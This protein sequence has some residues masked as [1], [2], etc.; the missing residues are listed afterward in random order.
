MRKRTVVAVLLLAAGLPVATAE[1]AVAD[2]GG[3]HAR[4]VTLI[5]GDRVLVPEGGR[6]PTILPAAGR[7][8]IAVHTH[9]VDGHVHVIPVDALPLVTAKRL[10]PR[11][12]DITGLLAA[13]YDDRRGDLPLIH[14]GPATRAPGTRVVRDLPALHAR[15][16]QADKATLPTSWRALTAAG[17]TVW[18][19]GRRQLTL[20]RSTAQIGAPEAWRS[21]LTGAGVTVAVLDTGV[22]QTHPDL[23]GREVAERNFTPAP[24]AV[25]RIGHGTH[26]ASI[27]AGGGGKY[28]GVANGARLL[29]A[30]VLDDTGFGQDSWIIAGMEWA[31]GQGATIV[32]LSL[33]GQDTPLLDPLEEA[34][35]RLSAEHGTLFVV[36]A[37]NNGIPGTIGSPA[38]A[39]AALAVG[40]VERDDSIAQFSSRG[41]RVGDGAIKPDITGPGVGIIA[42]K[43]AEGRIGDPA[44]PGYVRL[45]GTSMATPH[46]AGAAALLAQLHP[47]WTG[48]QLKAALTS[49]AKATP[50]ENVFAQGSG[51]VDVAAAIA[52]TV[53]SDP[54]S[55][56]LG[57]Q[58]WPHGDDVPVTKEITYRNNSTEPATL[59]LAAEAIGP[60]GKPA[61][62]G[63]IT[64]APARVVLPG[65]GSATARITADTRIGTLDGQ[66]TGA[67]VAR[68]GGQ[69]VRTTLLLDREVESYD[70]TVRYLGLDGKPTPNFTAFILALTPGA[71]SFRFDGS[72]EGMLEARLA[73]GRYVVGHTY[74]EQDTG[75]SRLLTQPGF[76]VT[77]ATELVVDARKAKPVKVAVPDPAVPL[78]FSYTGV[79]FTLN[80]GPFGFGL[81]TRDLDR[82]GIGQVGPTPT[83][84]DLT[85][86]LNATFLNQK[87]IYSLAWYRQRSVPDGFVRTLGKR[88]LATIRTDIATVLPDTRLTR[89][90]YPSPPWGS[91]GI[92][93]VVGK[94]V[95]AAA[96]EYVST[97]NVVWYSRTDIAAESPLTTQFISEPFTPKAGQTYRQRVNVGAF[98]PALP[99]AIVPWMER[100]KGNRIRFDLPLWSDQ[101][102]NAGYSETT[103]GRTRIY[104]NGELFQDNELPAGGN[105]PVPATAADL[106]F[107]AESTRDARFGLATKVTATWTTRSE[108]GQRYVPLAAVR[109]FPLL[110]AANSAPKGPAIV[111]VSLQLEDG[112]LTQ[113][114]EL[115]IDV[116]YDEGAT[117]RRAPLLARSLLLL[118]HPQGATSVSLRAAA[119]D[120][121]GITVDQTVIRAYKLR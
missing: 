55:V 109:F 3:D 88:D 34:V 68:G 47:R 25:D 64:V 104:I 26:V 107:I 98:G 105:V 29:D 81:V 116:S 23:A 57:T 74:I 59:D 83:D 103:S 86:S 39:D 111:P 72:P 42:A 49:S 106:K 28:R 52:L 99:R 73:K 77:R 65:G 117:W 91:S 80:G 76:D 46:V 32:N 45:S 101:V 78:L 24:D 15:A 119:K 94:P 20:D 82:L 19:D 93:L 120:S 37:G 56:N 43:A 13:G 79:E 92:T 27:I 100:L 48:A 9:T 10:D 118:N 11:L 61:P 110:D 84:G 33:G 89:T 58:L 75:Q 66:Y 40:A 96:T 44:E 70:V 53:T 108:P 50:G 112:T 87:D 1:S 121:R 18:L 41:P 97:E 51:R 8:G 69:S 7:E 30:K 63:L 67:V 38:S 71:T 17:A 62:P 31:I 102:G 4:T 95:Q 114:R 90:L 6:P 54:V 35:N 85:W 22:D 113:A 60:D 12:F 36:A 115:T 5:T 2:T 21:G 16:L 14:S